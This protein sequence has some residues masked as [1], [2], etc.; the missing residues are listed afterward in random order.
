MLPE[1]DGITISKKL[2][3]KIETPIIMITAR[4]SINQKLE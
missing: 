2:S 4:D 3:I 1:I